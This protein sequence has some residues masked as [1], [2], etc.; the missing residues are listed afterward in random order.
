MTIGMEM[1][2][3]MIAAAIATMSSIPASSSIVFPPVTAWHLCLIGSAEPLVVQVARGSI[4]HQEMSMVM[5]PVLDS[6]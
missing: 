6:D 4:T 5:L 1:A 2:L 3:P